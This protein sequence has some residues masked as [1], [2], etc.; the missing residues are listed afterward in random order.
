[1]YEKYKLFNFTETH[2]SVVATDT[3]ELRVHCCHTTG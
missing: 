2:C 1:M 3:V